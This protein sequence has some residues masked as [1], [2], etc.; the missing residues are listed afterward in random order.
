MSGWH[1]YERLKSEL[2]AGKLTAE[3][4]EQAIKKLAKELRL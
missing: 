4:Y 2:R 3:E 1:E